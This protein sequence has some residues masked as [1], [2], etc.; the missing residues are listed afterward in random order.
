MYGASSGVVIMPDYASHTCV[1]IS[2]FTIFKSSHYGIYYQGKGELLAS[3]NVLVD[4]QINVFTI[5]IEPGALTHTAAEKKVVIE[6]SLIVGKSTAFDC[7]KDVK[8]NGISERRS[9]MDSFGAGVSQRGK[10]G[11]VWPNFIGLNNR[12]PIYSW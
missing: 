3:E 10:I 12:A 5:V 4:N 8:P 11:I 2:A 7:L 1:K 9:V 6:N